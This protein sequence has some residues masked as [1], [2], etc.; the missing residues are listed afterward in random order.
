MHRVQV[1]QPVRQFGRGFGGDAQLPQ[2]PCLLYANANTLHSPQSTQGFYKVK[3]PLD[4]VIPT[5]ESMS[6]SRRER[7]FMGHDRIIPRM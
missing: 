1:N 4:L 6:H 3:L 7:S 5:Q 2:K